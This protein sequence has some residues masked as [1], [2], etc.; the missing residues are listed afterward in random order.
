MWGN[1]D[2]STINQGSI[3]DLSFGGEVPSGQASKGG[4]RGCIYWNDNNI[5]LEGGKLLPLKYPR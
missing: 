1:Q 5:F 4:P 2:I 3:K